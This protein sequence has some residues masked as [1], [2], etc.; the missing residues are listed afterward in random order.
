MRAN[1]S[2]G[3][4]VISAEINGGVKDYL[5]RPSFLHM[6]N[7][8]TPE[9]IKYI[10]TQC[11]ECIIAL[12]KGHVLSN[13]K[14]ACL[15]VIYACAPD[16][17]SFDIFGGLRE[18][19]DKLEF[20]KGSVSAEE[21]IIYANHLI[22][23]GVIG[24]P[25]KTALAM[26][27]KSDA[28]TKAKLFDPRAFVGDAIGHLGLSTDDAWRMTMTEWQRAMESKYPPDAK[29]IPIDENVLDDL[30][31]RAKA[32]LTKAGKKHG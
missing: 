29:K 32:A 2:I 4:I 27:K 9:E 26:S 17:M 23:W 3:E 22:K 25:S 21:I 1:T 10:F 7:L 20:V 8:G 30:E 19:G 5:L 28:E 15:D 24:D 6:N 16:D 11:A 31:A 14:F 13:Y 12:G 18:C